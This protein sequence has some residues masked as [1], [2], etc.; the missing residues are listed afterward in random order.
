[1]L[2][3]SLRVDVL[4][5]SAGFYIVYPTLVTQKFFTYTSQ[6]FSLT[7]IILTLP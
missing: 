6:S 4:K 2:I 7:F 1:M 5:D 3:Y